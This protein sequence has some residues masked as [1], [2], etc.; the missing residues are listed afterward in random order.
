MYDQRAMDGGIAA[1]VEVEAGTKPQKRAKFDPPDLS[2]SIH[3]QLVRERHL[4][5]AFVIVVIVIVV[6][7]DDDDKHDE[8][9]AGMTLT[10]QLTMN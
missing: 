9:D 6:D 7:D 3:C 8:G 4:S 10:D 5:I 2:Q 1:R